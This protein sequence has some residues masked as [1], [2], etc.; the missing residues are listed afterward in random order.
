MGSEDI[1]NFNVIF[2]GAGP[3]TLSCVTRLLQLVRQHNE[4]LPL[5]DSRRINLED[6]ICIIEKGCAIGSH[7]I[8]GALIEESDL[9]QII[10][11]PID[12]LPFVDGRIANEKV[13]FLTPR[14]SFQLPVIPPMLKNK[15]NYVVSISKFCKYLGDNLIKNDIPI[16]CSETADELIFEDNAVAGVFSYKAN[17]NAKHSKFDHQLKD[18]TRLNAKITVLGEGTHG[19]LSEKLISRLNLNTAIPR[20]FE[21]GIKELY[22]RLGPRPSDATDLCIQTMGYPLIQSGDTGGSF[23]YSTA[24]YVAIGLVAHLHSKN[25]GFNIHE[26]FQ[27]FKKHPLA[28]SQLQHTEIIEYGSKTIPCGGVSAN[29]QLIADGAIFLGDSAGLVDSMRLKGLG[30]AISSGVIA[31]EMLFHALKN[32]NY[33]L[34]TLR[35]YEEG[36]KSSYFF[37]RLKKADG[38]TQVMTSN[39]PFPAIP[40][41]VLHAI[42]GGT[43]IQKLTTTKPDYMCTKKIKNS[44]HSSTSDNESAMNS[45]TAKEKSVYFSHTVHSAFPDNHI[46]IKSDNVCKKCFDIYNAPCVSFC[47]SGVYSSVENRLHISAENCLHCRTCS[48]KCPFKNINWSIP[49]GG[50]GPKYF[51]M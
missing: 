15:G 1:L 51:N 3:A 23:I 12:G 35:K 13:C 39:I 36:V 10:S 31:A 19:Y 6:R 44:D 34:D 28:Q 17:P 7:A 26:A 38:F 43:L 16:F 11:E 49:D 5:N 46:T 25:P 41:A 4:N 9:H 50:T 30:N 24:Q 29:P 21:L 18:I 33:S 14:K 8:S 2:I 32:D 37:K 47:P 42:F 22:K 27:K 20:T 48:L 45:N 40:L